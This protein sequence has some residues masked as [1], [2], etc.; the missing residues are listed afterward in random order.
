[1][2]HRI[3]LSLFPGIDLLGK[4]FERAGFCV[5]RGPDVLFGGDV[6][7]FH[8]PSGV[9]EG[10]IG[11]PPCQVY[12]TANKFGDGRTTSVDLI[13]EYVRIINE[14]QPMWLVMEN[15]RGAAASPFIPSHWHS[16]DLCDWHCGGL[17][18]R[19]R[20]FWTHPQ[21]ITPPTDR[22]GYEAAEYS[23]L[24]SSWKVRTGIK[25][26]GGSRGMRQKTSIAEA[27]RLQ[28]FALPP[29]SIAKH[30]KRVAIHLLGNGVPLAMGAHIA[31]QARAW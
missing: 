31:K 15:V 18:K 2:T 10:V 9:F 30:S 16:T 4:A 20:R 27:E 13:G 22:P 5:V 21:R 28:G 11:G 3:V 1:M 17:T 8:V 29:D 14:A 26:K 7:S 19:V 25:G 12:S 24:A 6:R 23:V